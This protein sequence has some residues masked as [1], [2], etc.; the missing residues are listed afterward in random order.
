M[1][2][3]LGEGKQ[4]KPRREQSTCILLDKILANKNIK[5]QLEKKN[6]N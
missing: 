1:E 6:E 2:D 5:A 3:N 4:G